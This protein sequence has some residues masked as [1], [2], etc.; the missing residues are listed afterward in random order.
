MITCRSVRY[1]WLAYSS[2]LTTHLHTAPPRNACRYITTRKRLHV[3]V[4]LDFLFWTPAGQSFRG[5]N[6]RG[7]TR[8]T[9][10]SLQSTLP[11]S[12]RVSIKYDLAAEW[13][14]RTLHF[15]SSEWISCNVDVMMGRRRREFAWCRI[16]HHIMQRT[17]LIVSTA[18]SYRKSLKLLE[19][20]DFWIDTLVLLIKS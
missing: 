17:T 12:L 1:H 14:Y 3:L 9:S 8:Q 2:A 18:L 16:K 20:A 7:G 15:H 5:G 6:A 11:L 10:Y 19:E 4:V 13:Y